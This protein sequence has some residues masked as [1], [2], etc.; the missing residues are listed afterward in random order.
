M[1]IPANARRLDAAGRYVTP[2]LWDAHVHVM[3]AGVTALPVLIAHGVTSV[4]EMGGFLDSTRAWQA[5]MRAGTLV[6]LR[7][8]FVK[9]RTVASPEV[10]YAILR[11]AHRARLKVAGHLPGVVPIAVAADEEL[12]L[13]V[14]AGHT[15]QQALWSA[16]IG[17]AQFA[18]LDSAVGALV[19]GKAA[20]LVIL[21]AD[22]LAD[23]TNTRRIQA[24]IQAGRVYDR[25]ML[26][27]LL[28]SVRAPTPSR[29]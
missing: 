12:A 22:P 4:R 28:A 20:D 19:P 6:R 15:P 24:V 26:D 3:N 27:S 18:G 23:I 9:F 1:T 25:A 8:D 17:P 14:E 7:A 29:P 10:F 2:G 5:R 21:D 13:L 11:E 16:T